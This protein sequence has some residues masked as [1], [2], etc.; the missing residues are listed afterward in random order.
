MIKG[1]HIQRHVSTSVSL[2]LFSEQLSISGWVHFGFRVI[3]FEAASSNREN[4]RLRQCFNVR[5]AIIYQVALFLICSRFV[6]LDKRSLQTF[7]IWSM[8]WE[9]EN[10]ESF[11]KMYKNT[12]STNMLRYYVPSRSQNMH[13]VLNTNNGI[14]KVELF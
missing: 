2:I 13:P 9:T 6:D 1:G 11:S 12:D 7:H 14:L 10:Q 8:K 5:R 3:L 4:K